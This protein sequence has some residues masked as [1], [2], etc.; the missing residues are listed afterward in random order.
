MFTTIAA[1]LP[2]KKRALRGRR[3]VVV[4]IE[5]MVGGSVMTPLQV[6][7]VHSFLEAIGLLRGN[8]QAVVGASH[9][10]L[11][12][13]GLGW[14]GARLLVRSGE[15]GAD[16][17][18]LEVLTGEFV[19]S[20]FDEVILVSGDGIFADTVAALAAKGVAVTVVA[21]EDSCSKRLRMAAGRTVYMSPSEVIL[22]GAA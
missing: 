15:N 16:L 14:K 10:G 17:A 18:L 2:P 6:A 13:A 12:S 9:I 7:Q 19:E 21:R 11:L 3:L 8:D 22:E 20:R 5:N 4:D 1:V